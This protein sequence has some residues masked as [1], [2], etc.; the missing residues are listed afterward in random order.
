MMRVFCI[1]ESTV[2]NCQDNEREE[3]ISK[4]RIRKL[5]FDLFLQVLEILESQ[6]MVN[7]NVT[8]SD[9]YNMCNM[10]NSWLCLFFQDF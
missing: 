4:E 10:Y 7:F 6:R 5:I 2:S 3:G 1:F 9:E 8:R